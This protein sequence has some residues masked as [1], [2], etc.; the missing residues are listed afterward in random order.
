MPFS[1]RLLCWYG[2]KLNLVAPAARRSFSIADAD[3]PLDST[4]AIHPRYKTF[5]EYRD[6]VLLRSTGI[7]YNLEPATTML[8]SLPEFHSAALA[9]T[10]EWPYAHKSSANLIAVYEFGIVGVLKLYVRA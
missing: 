8:H 9:V 10:T 6:E 4:G 7:L 5:D 1:Q 3:S 2:A